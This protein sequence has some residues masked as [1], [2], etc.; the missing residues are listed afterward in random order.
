[1]RHDT[2]GPSAGNVTHDL[3]ETSSSRTTPARATPAHS[4]LRAALR[5]GMITG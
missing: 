4:A 5:C 2:P 1:M 3:Y